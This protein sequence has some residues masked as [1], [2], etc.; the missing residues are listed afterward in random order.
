MKRKFGDFKRREIQL[1]FNLYRV[2]VPSR[3]ISNSSLNV[4]D[5][6]PEG[7]DRTIMFVHGYAGVAETWEYQ[8]NYFANKYRVVLPDLRGHGR[9]EAAFL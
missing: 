8:A 3:E 4:I 2:N 1:D 9:S 7:V 6:W 5:L